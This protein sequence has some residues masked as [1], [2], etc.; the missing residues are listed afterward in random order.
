MYSLK[1]IDSIFTY[2]VG[3]NLE[4]RA[5]VTLVQ[6]DSVYFLVTFY[7]ASI[8]FIHPTSRSKLFA[9]FICSLIRTSVYPELLIHL[10]DV[11]WFLFPSSV[12]CSSSERLSI[13]SVWFIGSWRVS[14]MMLFD[15]TRHKSVSN[16]KRYFI[17]C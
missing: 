11:D 8:L 17:V 1:T 13:T 16:H 12:V 14:W 10:W 7:D 2:G 15:W 4:C 9:L 6:E 3:S 5:F